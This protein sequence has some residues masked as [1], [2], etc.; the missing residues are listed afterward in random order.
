V[1]AAA[2]EEEEEEK[3]NEKN[4]GKFTVY[5]KDT[6]FRNGVT[7][8]HHSPKHISLLHCVYFKTPKFTEII[9]Y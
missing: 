7:Y 2:E 9:C 4:V 3:G 5:H 6:S 8:R 1:I